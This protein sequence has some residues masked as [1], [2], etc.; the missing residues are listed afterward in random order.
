MKRSPPDKKDP[1]E[2]G[3]VGGAVTSAEEATGQIPVGSLR[4]ELLPE[5]ERTSGDHEPYGAHEMPV[6][7]K[8][9]R[10]DADRR[11][12]ATHGDTRK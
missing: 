1:G 4:E 6:K 9:N 7:E 10:R 11:T 12:G 5:D 3:P 8:R 2:P